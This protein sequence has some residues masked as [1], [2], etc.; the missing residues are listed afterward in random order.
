MSAA[1]TCSARPSP[2]GEGRKPDLRA[3]VGYTL[4]AMALGL[5]VKA[6]YIP[7][8]AELAQ[9][10]LER[11]FTQS[12]ASGQP[13]KAWSWADTW[14]VAKLQV[15]R[16]GASAIVLKGASGEALAFGPSLL[17]ETAGIGGRG[18]AVIAAHRDTHFAFLKD[19]QVGDVVSLT[20]AD[21]LRFDYR[22]TGMRMADA[23][24]SGIDRHA[25]GFQLVLST[26]YPFDA[27]LHGKQRYLVEAEMVK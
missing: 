21:G 4:V 2:K 1:F 12:V 9:I 23:D 27:V 13:V 14:P 5:S 22:V 10:L 24:A 18:T 3:A 8:K 7:I 16:I 6:A 20:R 11:A 15:E 26:C 19:V 25:P 17:D